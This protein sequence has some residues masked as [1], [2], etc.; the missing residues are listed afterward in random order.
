M[1][2]KIIALS[3][4]SQTKVDAQCGISNIQNSRKCKAIYGDRKEM[5]GCLNEEGMARGRNNRIQQ[6]GLLTWRI[7]SPPWLWQLDLNAF[8]QTCQNLPHCTLKYA[9]RIVYQF[10]LIRLWNIHENSKQRLAKSEM[11]KRN[12]RQ[13]N[14]ST[15]SITLLQSQL[16]FGNCCW[17]PCTQSFR[18]SILLCIATGIPCQSPS[19]CC[20]FLWCNPI[21]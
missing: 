11:L 9:F 8:V 13:K 1:N 21:L 7:C 15:Y 2:F 20:S 18:G 5:R 14:L 17:V 6:R 4:R 16:A 10:C 12:K 3:K 19:L